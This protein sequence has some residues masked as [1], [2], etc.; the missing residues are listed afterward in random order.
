MIPSVISLASCGAYLC[1]RWG[2]FRGELTADHWDEIGQI[3]DLL[4][5][6]FDHRAF[7]RQLAAGLAAEGL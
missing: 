5:L 7:Y 1:A 3:A 4:N 2:E 6:P